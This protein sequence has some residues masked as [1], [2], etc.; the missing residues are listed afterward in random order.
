MP[1]EAS[2]GAGTEGW[3][4]LL[5]APIRPLDPALQNPSRPPMSPIPGTWQTPP[6][7]AGPTRP[8][9][10]AGPAGW[11]T[12]AAR[13][14]SAGWATCAGAS[15][16]PAWTAVAG[17][18]ADTAWTAVAG[19]PA[20]SAAAA[21]LTAACAGPG[22]PT[23]AATTPSSNTTRRT[24]TGTRGQRG[25]QDGRVTLEADL[26]IGPAPEVG[27]G[28][29]FARLKR[30]GLGISGLLCSGRRVVGVEAVCRPYLRRT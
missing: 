5:R 28:S 19:A 30:K 20:D 16:A 29:D 7:A 4:T 22:R 24:D 21:G 23:T 2:S 18:P 27:A 1:P 8:V 15:G 11:A 25:I 13:A 14:G 3:Q 10:L 12:P 26:G 9:T 17:A 6:G